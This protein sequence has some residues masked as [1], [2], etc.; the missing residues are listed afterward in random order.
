MPRDV[1][2]LSAFLHALHPTETGFH[3]LRALPSKAQAFVPVGDV[4]GVTAFL[5]TY[6]HENVYIG[7]ATRR[8]ATTGKL[9][10]C[11]ELWNLFV[12]LDFKTVAEPDA[13][14]RLAVFPLPPTLV[15]HSGGGFHVYWHLREP[16]RFPADADVAR[17]WLRRLA[18]HFDGDLSSA[19]PAHVL[20]I[21]G[22]WNHKP[23]Y[24]QARAVNLV[25]APC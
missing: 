2:A 23:I 17:A 4:A 14:A 1:H 5:D 13:R 20:R 11:A 12:D 10:N 7:V 9:E 15:V 18:R 16:L 6:T 24:P 19:E 22:S 3:E 21:P 8:T 25:D